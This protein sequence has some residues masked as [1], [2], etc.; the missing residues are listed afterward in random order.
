VSGLFSDISS[1]VLVSS[2]LDGSVV[3]WDLLS[4]KSQQYKKLQDQS[5]V[6]LMRGNRLAGFVAVASQKRN[7]YVFDVYT[8]QLVRFLGAGHTR[9]ITDI[10]LNSRQLLTSSLDSTIRVWD[11]PSGLCTNWLAFESAV[12]SMAVSPSSEYLCVGLCDETGTKIL[13]YHDDIMTIS[14]DGLIMVL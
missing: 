5:A 6:M 4:H 2:S 3:F 12:L 7:V 8:Q 11:L 9:N 1:R 10:V 13:L 14:Y